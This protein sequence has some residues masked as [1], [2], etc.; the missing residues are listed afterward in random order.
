MAYYQ[1]NFRTNNVVPN[2]IRLKRHSRSVIKLSFI[3]AQRF[4]VTIF[5]FSILMDMFKV[6]S[7]I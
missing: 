2:N 6:E 3:D 4:K 1:F 7:T 5:G